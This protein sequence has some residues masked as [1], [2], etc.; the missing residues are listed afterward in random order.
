M[1]VSS[2]HYSWEGSLVGQ[3]WPHVPV[4][5]KWLVRAESDYIQCCYIKGKT[6]NV[7]KIYEIATVKL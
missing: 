4:V 7:T 3:L 2:I 1:K 6:G 5:G